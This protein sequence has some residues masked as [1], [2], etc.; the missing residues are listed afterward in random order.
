[1][2]SELFQIWGSAPIGLH[3][4]TQEQDQLSKISSVLLRTLAR[5][6]TVICIMRYARRKFVAP[7]G[8]LIDVRSFCW[9]AQ[10]AQV[11]VVPLARRLVLES[12]ASDTCWLCLNIDLEHNCLSGLPRKTSVGLSE[13]GRKQVLVLLGSSILTA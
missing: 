4:L 10:G 11:Q 13:A 6:Y 12:V 2:H 8:E 1:M 7:W 5:N 9:Q 3:K